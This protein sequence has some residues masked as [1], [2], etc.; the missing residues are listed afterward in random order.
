MSAALQVNED[1]ALRETIRVLVCDD[2]PTYA[3]ALRRLLERGEE[4]QVVAVCPT[5]ES[6]IAAIEDVRPDLVT[7]DVELPGMSG[8]DAV[9]AIMRLHPVPI[10][11]LSS[12]ARPGGETVEAAYAAGA[13]ASIAK[14]D[15]ELRDPDGIAAVALRR[16]VRMLASQAS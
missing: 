10:L 8:V 6:A 3:A 14:D 13:A 16:R 2:S 4:I 15:L 7:M 12:M 11:V 1:H 5:A 9:E